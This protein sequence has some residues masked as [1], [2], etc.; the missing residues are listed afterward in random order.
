V[1]ASVRKTGKVLLITDAVEAA[2]S[3]QTGGRHPDAAL[4]RR[5]RCAAG[6]IGSRNW[7]TRAAE[8][9]ALFFLSRVADRTPFTS[10]YCR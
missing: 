1:A 8:L 10:A 3:C 4:L 2:A 7:I 6:V 5:S 9:E